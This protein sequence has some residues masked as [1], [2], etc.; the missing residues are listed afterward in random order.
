MACVFDGKSI[1]LH[2]WRTYG[3]NEH[4][5]IKMMEKKRKVL[6]EALFFIYRKIIFV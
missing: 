6:S 1:L 4:F 5:F 2:E 3:D